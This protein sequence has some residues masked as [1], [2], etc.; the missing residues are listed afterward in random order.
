MNR[1]WLRRR[2]WMAAG[3]SAPRLT[4]SALA[5]LRDCMGQLSGAQSKVEVLGLS[6]EAIGRKQIDTLMPRFQIQSN[7][8]ECC[9]RR[10][11]TSWIVR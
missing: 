3:I 9:N 10:R 2:W 1:R 7:S 5:G 11:K 4:S 6:Q 8:A